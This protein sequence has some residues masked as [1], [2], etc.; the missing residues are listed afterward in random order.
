MTDWNKL[1][2]NKIRE[3]QAAGAKPEWIDT[4]W[5][6]ALARLEADVRDIKKAIFNFNL[7]AP[8]EASRPT[9]RVDRFT[10]AP[11]P[12]RAAPPESG[13]ERRSSAKRS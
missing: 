8:A 4:H 12:A 5:K 7:R 6:R 3:A 1:V 11:A 2:E 10:R 9:L 13:R